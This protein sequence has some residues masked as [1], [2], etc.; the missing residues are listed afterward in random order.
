MMENQAP[1][2]IYI[3]YCVLF[4]G[5]DVAVLCMCMFF[6]SFG[7]QP[8]PSE[9]QFSKKKTP[10]RSLHDLNDHLEGTVNIPNQ[11]KKIST[12]MFIPFLC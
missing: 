12:S 7:A 2:V 1:V 3:H 11:T 5:N 9:E 10:F 6:T 4:D 8:F